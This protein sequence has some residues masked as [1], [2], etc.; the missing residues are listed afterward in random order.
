MPRAELDH[1]LDVPD[2]GADADGFVAVVEFADGGEEFVDAVVFDDDHDGGVHLGPGVGA[3]AGFACAGAAALDL[4]EEG[5]TGYLEFVEH[6]F[7]TLGISLIENYKY[8]LHILFLL[9]VI[10]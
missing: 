9:F 7:H 5:E 1:L 6:V 8:T 4:L 2:E 10:G 3:A